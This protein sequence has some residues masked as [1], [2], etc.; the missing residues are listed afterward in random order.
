M[1]NNSALKKSLMFLRVASRFLFANAGSA[2]RNSSPSPRD[3]S[4]ASKYPTGGY[5]STI[6]RLEI[7]RDVDRSG[8]FARLVE[9][10]GRQWP[11]V[12]A[13]GHRQLVSAYTVA[14]Y[15]SAFDQH[16]RRCVYARAAARY[17]IRIS[18]ALSVANRKLAFTQ[19]A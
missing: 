18:R 13:T 16:S 19:S 6:E 9:I 12:A 10:S 14:R 2:T 3:L 1:P 7:E 4:R 11:G 15:L 5:I 17:A 8:Q